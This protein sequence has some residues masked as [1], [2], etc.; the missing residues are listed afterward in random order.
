MMRAERIGMVYLDREE[1]VF[2]RGNCRLT[3]FQ[4]PYIAFLGSFGV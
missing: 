3:N 4:V 2:R 1:A